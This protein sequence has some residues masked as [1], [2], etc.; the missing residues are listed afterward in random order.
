[1]VRVWDAATGRL[2][3]RLLGPNGYTA[4]RFSP[5][6]DRVVIAS[7]QPNV[8]IWPISADAA[9]VV[10]KL[11][12]GR[13]LNVARFDSSGDRIV[14]ADSGPTHSSTVV[15]RSLR[16]GRE[17]AL[18]GVPKDEVWDA[19]FAPD[20]Q[21]IAAV[22]ESGAVMVWRLDR[23][24]NP[25]RE[26]RGHRGNVNALAYSR[27]GRIATAGA[28]R[29]V[30]IW[31]PRGGPEVVLR[32]HDEDVTTVVFTPGG[33][34]VISSSQDGTVRLWDAGGGEALAVL[35]T[36]QD[37]V[38]DVARSRDGKIATLGKD[39]VV[40]VFRCGVCGSL[41]QVR[42]LALSRVTRPLT[43]AERQRFLGG[44]R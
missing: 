17:V 12:A 10:A 29:T 8:R 42:A 41:A 16:S 4:A 36:R 33:R 5:S 32:G 3:A 9:R 18:G 31:N 37:A 27:D 20:G 35:E 43:P 25:E 38:L 7:D 14:Y 2:R 28:D 26:L 21:H 40:R 1:M 30:R 13:W 34:R 6:D 11:H 19:R 24:A 39:G 22:F 44:T 15:V 23:P